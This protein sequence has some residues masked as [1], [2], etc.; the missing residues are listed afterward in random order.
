MFLVTTPC[1][2]TFRKLDPY[3]VSNITCSLEKLQVHLEHSS[4]ALVHNL[5]VQLLV[6]PGCS[7]QSRHRKRAQ[8]KWRPGKPVWILC[9]LPPA[10]EP[11]QK[12]PVS[13]PY[14]RLSW[15]TAMSHHL[16]CFCPDCW[17]ELRE[18]NTRTRSMLPVLFTSVTLQQRLSAVSP[19]SL[20]MK[21][22]LHVEVMSHLCL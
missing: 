14:P 16:R 12:E 8:K 20:I 19:L 13:T 18:P 9:G 17:W 11:C 21:V 4:N 2:L 10:A 15:N 6:F 5:S 7:F 1:H 3:S 22:C